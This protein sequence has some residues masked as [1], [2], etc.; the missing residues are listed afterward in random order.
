MQEHRSCVEELLDQGWRYLDQDADTLL[1]LDICRLQHNWQ[2]LNSKLQ[3]L[4]TR[5]PERPRITT[6]N[7]YFSPLNCTLEQ[8]NHPTFTQPKR[9]LYFAKKKFSVKPQFRNNPLPKPSNI[10]NTRNLELGSSS[11]HF[12]ATFGTH[13][14]ENRHFTD[15]LSTAVTKDIHLLHRNKWKP[16]NQLEIKFPSRSHRAKVPNPHNSSGK[17]AGNNSEKQVG[18]RNG[19]RT[20]S[21]H[22]VL[23]KHFSTSLPS[24]ETMT[25]VENKMATKLCDSISD[26]FMDIDVDQHSTASAPVPITGQT[27][28]RRTLRKHRDESPVSP[29]RRRMNHEGPKGKRSGPRR[30]PRFSPTALHK[31]SNDLSILSFDN[32]PKFSIEDLSQQVTPD[33]SVLDTQS[34]SVLAQMNHTFDSFSDGNLT[35]SRTMDE[36]S[37][38]QISSPGRSPRDSPVPSFHLGHDV[39][40]K[41]KYRKDELWA[42]IESDYQYLMDGE[43]IEQC[44]VGFSTSF[45]LLKGISTKSA[46][47]QVD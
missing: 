21:S 5:Q 33:G 32:L 46:I 25:A 47:Y 4:A 19:K 36:L 43:I 40:V 23:Q 11:P 10:E 22:F 34:D 7:E 1:Y 37:D 2:D 24:S 41:G 8:S 12:E 26:L 13:T 29:K 6:H 31:T 14:S 38:S 9:Y 30:S 3:F 16:V 42:A 35:V 20:N 44:K 17:V 39:N 15:R 27:S 45:E 18:C 28:P